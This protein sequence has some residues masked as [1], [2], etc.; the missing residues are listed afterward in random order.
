MA[1]WEDEV[2]GDP[3]MQEEPCQT[4]HL[5][6]RRAALELTH[7]ELSPGSAQSTMK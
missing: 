4:P 7:C 6:R 2:V 1:S 5:P 3:D